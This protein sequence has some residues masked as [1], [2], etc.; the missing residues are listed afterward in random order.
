MFLVVVIWLVFLA[1]L[2]F[3]GQSVIRATWVCVIAIMLTLI[4]VSIWKPLWFY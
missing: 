1:F 4:A 3:A 2:G